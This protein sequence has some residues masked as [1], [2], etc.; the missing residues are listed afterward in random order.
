M[1]D[2]H[3]LFLNIK[4]HL[5]LFVPPKQGHRACSAHTSV[6]CCSE[7]NNFN[8]F[9]L[10][11]HSLPGIIQTKSFC[12]FPKLN[13]L[14]FKSCKLFPVMLRHDFPANSNP[15]QLHTL[16]I[17]C[18]LFARLYSHVGEPET[19]WW[20]IYKSDGLLWWRPLLNPIQMLHR[21]TVPRCFQ[22]HS[23]LTAVDK[24]AGFPEKL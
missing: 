11:F 9:I 6:K 10:F 1:H 5:I 19:A 22:V 16:R 3:A 18:E 20:V 21:P 8:R 13:P 7:F 24:L 17:W 23:S 14:V 4:P 12:F 2:Q 15:F